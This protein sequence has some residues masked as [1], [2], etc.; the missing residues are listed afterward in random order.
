MEE[1]T[2][3]SKKLI[4]DAL[5]FVIFLIITKALVYFGNEAPIGQLGSINYPLN[6]SAFFVAY[7]TEAIAIIYLLKFF[8]SLYKKYKK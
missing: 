5:L 4:K 2:T 6:I 7:I 8:Y 1:S 3:S